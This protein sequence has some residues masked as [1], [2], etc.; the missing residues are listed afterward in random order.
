MDTGREG[1]WPVGRPARLAII[2]AVV[3]LLGGC[4]GLMPRSP[5][6]TLAGIEIVEANLFE[7][8]FVFQLRIQNPN[9][10]EISIT[11]LNF[12]VEING[13]SFAK[14]VGDKPVTVPRLGEAILEVKAVST[15]TGLLR[16]VDEMV[17]G[18]RDGVTY[19][20]RGRLFTGAFGNFDFDEGG[21]LEMPAP[22]PGS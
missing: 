9:A 7:Q 4:A 21:R 3:L 18:S 5:S 1:K 14:G 16:Q 19:R 10:M 2:V 6:V 17:R 15:L 20:I 12:E 11:G 8:R 13:Q 22:R